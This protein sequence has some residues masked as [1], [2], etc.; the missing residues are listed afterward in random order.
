VNTKIYNV[1]GDRSHIKD[2][3]YLYLYAS[4]RK[5]N[6][7]RLWRAI[8]EDYSSR[9]LT[10][11]DDELPALSGLAYQHLQTEEDMYLAG[12]W[13][14]LLEQLCWYVVTSDDKEATKPA[15]YR[16][17]SWSWAHL[18]GTVRFSRGLD[19]IFNKVRYDD[20][21]IVRVST[22]EAGQ[23]PMG[24]VKDG[25]ITLRANLPDKYGRGNL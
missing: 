5:H 2:T 6:F 23:D 17:P 19:L 1:S 15:H 4:D 13:L 16:A 20:I 10:N 12:V 8:V 24:K 21:E 25:S 22:I 18:D 3:D 7:Q 11:S 14:S 9:Q